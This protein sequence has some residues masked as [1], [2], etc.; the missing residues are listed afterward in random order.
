MGIISGKEFLDRLDQLKNELWFDGKKI[1]GNISE[2]PAFKGILETKSSLYDLQTS[3]GLIDEMTCFLPEKK[4]RIG[5]S[6]LQPKTKEDLKRRRRMIEHWARHTHGMM[7]RSPDYMNTVIMS[8]ASSAPLL[9][10]RENCFPEHIQSLYDQAMKH[11]LSFTHTFI[12]P[13]VNRSQMNITTSENPISAKI[14]D[15]NDKGIVIKG[16]RLLATQG[17]LTDEIL[18][19]SAPRFYFEE[20][21]AF[22]FSIPSNTQ[23]VKF[24]CRE[25]FVLGESA[26]DH[27]LGSRYEEMDSV[28]VFDDVL[29]PWDRVFFYGDAETANGFLAASSFNAFSYH[30]VITRQIVK[31]EFLL[32]VSQLLVDT[33][34]VSE[35]QHIQ[36]KL[37]EIVTGLE[38]LKALLEKSEHDAMLDGCGYMRPSLIPLQIASTVFPKIYPRFTEIIQ[39]IGASGIMTI[40]TESAFDS[41]IKEDLDHYLQGT[42]INGKDRVKLFR[43]AWD[44][45]MSPFGTRQTQYER[46]FYGDPVRLASRLYQCYP[47]EKYVKAVQEFLHVKNDSSI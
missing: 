24:I 20:D 28:V 21:E 11:D 19:L 7:G 4:E 14:V 27:P 39:L 35:Y 9:H 44:L 29:V 17:G 3:D 13:Q 37:S 2:H 16:A 8:F 18:V 30:Q 23:G 6:Y 31:T 12:T 15:R 5:L 45:T 47:K 10:D 22:A 38:T 43:L 32:G 36:E 42:G 40:P 46:F 34:N 41:E 25:S 33:I 1:E 26:F